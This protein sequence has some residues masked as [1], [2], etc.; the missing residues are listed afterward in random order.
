MH[1]NDLAANRLIL[2]HIEGRP[3]T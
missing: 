1:L 3:C 2:G